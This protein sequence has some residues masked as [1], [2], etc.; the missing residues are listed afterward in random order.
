MK[1]T[2]DDVGDDM[3]K[4]RVDA[5]VVEDKFEDLKESVEDDVEDL[6]L[7]LENNNERYRK[8]SSILYCT[9]LF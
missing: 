8:H 5:L 1:Q 6:E 7:E 9:G 2:Q 3:N 4:I